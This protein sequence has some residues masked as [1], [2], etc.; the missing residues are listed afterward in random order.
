MNDVQDMCY[1]IDD[2]DDLAEAALEAIDAA[3]EEKVMSKEVKQEK[4][5]NVDMSSK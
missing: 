1:D 4:V 2:N 3:P 5:Q